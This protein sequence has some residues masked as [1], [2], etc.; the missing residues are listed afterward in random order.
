M[1]VKPLMTT[2]LTNFIGASFELGTT[3]VRTWSEVDGASVPCLKSCAPTVLLRC[4]DTKNIADY[5]YDI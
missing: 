4:F 5:L 1:P 3:V 2:N